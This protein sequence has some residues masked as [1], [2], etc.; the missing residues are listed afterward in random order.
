MKVAFCN[1]PTW[2]S[3]LGGDGIQMLKTKEV[4]EHKYNVEIDIITDIYDL[5]SNYDIIHVFN[6]LTYKISYAYVQ[7]GKELGI[8]VVISSIFW[9]YTFAYNKLTNLFVTNR[10]SAFSANL[11]RVIIHTS[12]FIIQKPAFFSLGFKH[13]LA[14]CCKLSAAILP[15]SIEEGM[16]LQKFVN[17]EELQTKISVVY[18]GTDASIGKLGSLSRTEFFQ[19]YNLPPKYILQVARIEPVK[20]QINLLYA[21]MKYKEFPIV[22][23]GKVVNAYYFKRLKFLARKRGNVYFVDAVPHEEIGDFYRYA[24]VHVLLSL[25][26]SPGLVSLEALSYG[27]PIVVSNS[28][29]APVET[30]FKSEPYI[31]DP[32]NFNEISRA[33]IAASN[34]SRREVKETIFTWDKAAEQT[35]L[36]YNRILQS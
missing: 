3:P 20:N 18:N 6:L 9:D 7:R 30:Y 12:A 23:L 21:L 5:T 14:K 35:Y 11:I 22:F 10:L 32:F 26:E 16:L 29:Y 31:V 24:S 28:A 4:L 1:R 19:K 13:T 8:P 36:V 25:R 33:V 2:N 15:N 27:C 17:I 34:S